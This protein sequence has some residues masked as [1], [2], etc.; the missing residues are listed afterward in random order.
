MSN[1]AVFKLNRTLI[2][3]NV[4]QIED[5][6]G[7]AIHFHVGLVRFDLS[8]KEFDK[9][10]ETLLGVLNEQ[11]MMKNF[12]L[13]YQNEYF[14]ERIAEDIPYI[15]E[16][17]EIT[18]KVSDLKYRYQFDDKEVVISSLVET[19]IYKYYQ[20]NKNIHNN[21]ILDT[22]IWQ[23][24]EQLLDEVK[25]NRN[26]DIYVDDEFFVL[27][28]YKSLCA[29]LAFSDI[30]EEIHVKQIVFSKGHRPEYILKREIEQWWLS[31]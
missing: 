19:P 28:G 23:N 17:K 5:N 3:N 18:T 1:P 13:Q 24:K 27:D 6:I 12:D 8:I 29:G 21:Y 10:T 31:R 22:E 30:P 15:I 20:G 16:V 14:L 25:K 7:E 2:R 26:T 4:F 11:L 9:I